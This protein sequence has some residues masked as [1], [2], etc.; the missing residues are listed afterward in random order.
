MNKKIIVITILSIITG[1]VLINIINEQDVV[2]EENEKQI[3]NSNM[4]TMMLMTI[5][6][7]GQFFTLNQM[8]H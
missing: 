3:T 2:M 8:Q 5:M 1:L 6:L 4:L 7:L